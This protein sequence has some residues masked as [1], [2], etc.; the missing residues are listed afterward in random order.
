MDEKPKK[1]LFKELLP[2]IIIVFV[3]IFIRTFIITPV[4]VE[5]E[6]MY[7]NLNDGEILILKKYDKAYSRFDVVVFNYK[8]D[9]LIKR[10]IGLPGEKVEYKNNKLYIDGK[11]LKENFKTNSPTIDF[12]LEEIGYDVIPDGY[13][14]VMGDNRNNSTD[15]RIIGL[16]SKDD[17]VGSTNFSLF[18]FST[19][20][21]I[22]K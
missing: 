18:P 16:V 9:K 12:K 1:N 5:G 2:Y 19:I 13:Y 11:L 17:I 3:V 14:F 21:K 8:N 10:V 22:N 6:S 4:R 15:S 7:P 20:G